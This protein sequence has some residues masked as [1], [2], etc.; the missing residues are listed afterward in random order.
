MGHSNKTAFHSGGAA[1]FQGTYRSNRTSLPIKTADTL[2]N[3]IKEEFHSGRAYVKNELARS[4]RTLALSLDVWTSE[5]QIAIMG[6]IG[7]WIS[8]DFEKR[9][10][11][12]EFTEINGPHSGENLAEVVL[13]MLDELDIAPKLLTITGDNAGNNGTLCDSLHDQLLKKYDNDDDRFRIR[14]LMRFPPRH[15]QE[16]KEVSPSKKVSY[17]VDTRWNSTYLMIQDALRLQ[18]ELG[19][20]VQIHPEVQ[21]LQ[22]IDDE[23]STLQQVAKILKPFSD[24]TNSVSKACPTI[25]ESLPIYWSLDDLLNDVRNAEGDF[26]DVNIEIRDAVERGIR[27][28]N[29]FARKMDDNLL[30]YVASV[31]DPRIKSSLILSRMSEQDSGLIVSQVREFLKKEY[32]PEPFVSREVDHLRPPGMSETM[33]KTLRKV[34]PSKEVSLSDIDKYLDSPQVNWS[35][36]MIGDADAEWVLKWWKANAFNFPLMAKAARDYLPIPSAE[37]GIER[38]FSNA[39]DVL[40]LRRHRLTRRLCDG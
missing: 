36:H 31:L 19:Q 40:G 6:I 27:K 20:F 39:R 25:V 21:A 35:H 11:L 8:P 16:W 29:K 12:L 33:W 7:H 17:D 14:P 26:E 9:E 5:N 2:F 37:V 3:R 34:Q 22:L 1:G 30:Y 13:K 10:E 32:P 38:E 24:H 23:W 28:M 4:S 15:H 18:T